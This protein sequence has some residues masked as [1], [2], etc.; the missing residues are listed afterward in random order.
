MRDVEIMHFS[1]KDLEKTACDLSTDDVMWTSSI[2]H[3]SCTDCLMSKEGLEA[4]DDCFICSSARSED[5]V[6]NNDTTYGQVSVNIRFAKQ[7]AHGR[8]RVGG[9]EVTLSELLFQI[10][11]H[12]DFDEI[13]E[14]TGLNEVEVSNALSDL[15]QLLDCDWAAI[16]NEERL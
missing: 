6:R 14:I 8:P 12:A 2:Q 9:T 3:V 15:S 13:L 4:M 11:L 10:S 7:I 1:G 5:E 16:R